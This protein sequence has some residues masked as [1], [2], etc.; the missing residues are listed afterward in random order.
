MRFLRCI[1]SI[2][3]EHMVA[4]W[5]ANISMHWPVTFAH[6]LVDYTNENF[7]SG[8]LTRLLGGWGAAMSNSF[9]L[10]AKQAAYQTSYFKSPEGWSLGWIT[11]MYSS[12]GGG[13]GGGGSS[14]SNA[15]VTKN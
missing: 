8:I 6:M 2:K 7:L 14:G 11:S 5:F 4:E 12:G 1:S 10:V 9:S 15:P 13:G 3:I